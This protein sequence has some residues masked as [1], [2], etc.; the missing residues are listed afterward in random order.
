MK[1]C[2]KCGLNCDVGSIGLKDGTFAHK[3]CFVCD[4]CKE[5]L[6]LKYA[7]KNNRHFH[8]PVNILMI[9]SLV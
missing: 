3:Q 9:D 7:T 4:I 8:V 6:P 2:T 5:E 1:I